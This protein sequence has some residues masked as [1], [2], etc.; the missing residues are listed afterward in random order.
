MNDYNPVQI[1]TAIRECASRI[2][3]GVTVCGERYKAYL[4]A[5]RAYDAAFA[6]AYLEANGPAHAKKYVAE[7]ATQEERAIRDTTDAAYKYAD[8]R[9]RALETELRAWQS[10]NKSVIGMYSAAGA[11]ER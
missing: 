10:V 1:E 8:R 4:D 9:A 3:K 2:A 11:G 7:L 6:H 5:D